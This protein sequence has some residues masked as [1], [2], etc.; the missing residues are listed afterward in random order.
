MFFAIHMIYV[1]IRDLEL[2]LNFSANFVE[3]DIA[4]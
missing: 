2:P 1:M 3:V 4:V